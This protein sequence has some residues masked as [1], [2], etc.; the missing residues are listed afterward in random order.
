MEE[1]EFNIGNY[2]FILIDTFR[3]SNS[4][5]PYLIQSIEPKD[6]Q[7]NVKER[8]RFIDDVGDLEGIY[9]REDLVRKALPHEIPNYELKYEIW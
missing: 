5:T 2:F 4:Y 6:Y 9:I 3:N 7:G 8:I 1:S